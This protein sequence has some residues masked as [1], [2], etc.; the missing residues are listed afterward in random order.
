MLIWNLFC[1]DTSHS[2][3][4]YIILLFNFYHHF[5]ILLWYML[6]TDQN[7]HFY[8]IYLRSKISDPLLVVN[9]FFRIPETNLCFFFHITAFISCSRCTS[10]SGTNLHNR[11]AQVPSHIISRLAKCSKC[12]KQKLGQGGKLVQLAPEWTGWVRISRISR[13][14]EGNGPIF[15]NKGKKCTD[16]TIRPPD[17]AP[18][19]KIKLTIMSRL[20]L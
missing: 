7:Q 5:G 12:S 2:Q 16:W 6:D 17:R 9:L 11:N 18:D 10:F 13:V 19:L 14:K 8:E 3:H 4:I 15:L 1:L 20:L